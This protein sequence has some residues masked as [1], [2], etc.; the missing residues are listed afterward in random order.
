MRGTTYFLYAQSIISQL[1]SRAFLLTFSHKLWHPSDTEAE[2]RYQH[3]FG[4]LHGDDLKILQYL[5]EL[6][7][8]HMTGT[9]DTVLRFSYTASSVFKI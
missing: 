2:V 4:E 8:Q 6:I 3:V 1:V 7:T 5:S 9:S